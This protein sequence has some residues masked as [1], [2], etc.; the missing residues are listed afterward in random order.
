MMILS[1]LR[2]RKIICALFA[3]VFMTA[4]GNAEHNTRF[5]FN[6]NDS[7]GS[8]FSQQKSIYINESKDELV[9][10]ASLKIDGGKAEVEVISSDSKE[11]VSSFSYESD[12]DFDIILKDVQEEQEYIISVKAEQ[13]NKISLV[14]SASEKLVRDK[15]KPNKP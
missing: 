6:F 8:D 15:E 2:I 9:L 4:C 13:T 5:E 11:S 7:Q 3:C 1:K 14:V 10:N 12:T